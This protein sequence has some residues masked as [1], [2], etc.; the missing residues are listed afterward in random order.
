M[1]QEQSMT[2]FNYYVGAIAVGGGLITAAVFCCSLLPRTRMKVFQ[3]TLQETGTLLQQIKDEALVPVLAIYEFETKLRILKESSASLRDSTHQCSSLLREV[4]AAYRGLSTAIK[5][6]TNHAIDLQARIATASEEQR[7]APRL[8]NSLMCGQPSALS[9]SSLNSE[10]C[11]NGPGLPDSDTQHQSTDV[12]RCFSSGPRP[13]HENGMS[14]IGSDS[15]STAVLSTTRI[16][17][18]RAHWKT[19]LLAFLRQW[20]HPT[21][22][23]KPSLD[24]ESGLPTDLHAFVLTRSLLSCPLLPLYLIAVPSRSLIALKHAYLNVTPSDLFFVP[25]VLILSPAYTSTSTSYSFRRPRFISGKYQ[26][27]VLD[28]SEFV[29][30][31][32]ERGTRASPTPYGT[33]PSRFDILKS[34]RKVVRVWLTRDRPRVS[35][36]FFSSRVFLVVDNVRSP[37]AGLYFIFSGRLDNLVRLGALLSF[38]HSLI[39]MYDVRASRSPPSR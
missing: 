20:R 18:R 13:L 4:I 22:Q 37:L 23:D 15:S 14:E 25:S 33:A 34:R 17:G 29:L 27:F 2:I 24:L 10:I 11:A 39:V 7:R 35:K 9:T 32:R 26:P 31:W 1:D 21:K 19:C 5:R 12:A 38:I 16:V 6:S 36:N 30:F 3:R 8:S 28:I